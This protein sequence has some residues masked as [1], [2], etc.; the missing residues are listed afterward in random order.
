MG[1]GGSDHPRERGELIHPATG[2]DLD[3]GSSPRARG[4]QVL[5]TGVCQVGRIIPAS[6][7]NSRSRQRPISRATDHPRERGELRAATLGTV[8]VFGSSPR[9]R[10]TRPLFRHA[11]LLRRIIPASAGNSPCCPGSRAAKPDHPRERG[12][13]F[14][15]WRR[16][17]RGC[18]SSPR[19]RG[20]RQAAS[21]PC[22]APR[23]IPASAG[24]SQPVSDTLAAD[25]DHPRERGE[26]ET[27][28]DM[29]ICRA[30]SS[31]RAR[32]TLGKKIGPAKFL[33]IIP[34]SAG[35]SRVRQAPLLHEPDHPRERGELRSAATTFCTKAGSSP[36]ARGTRSRRVQIGRG[37]RIIPASAGNSCGCGCSGTKRPDHPRER[38]ELVTRSSLSR[39]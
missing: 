37:A 22:R 23:I 38:G 13:L 17:A 35:N 5:A 15:C 20:T 39:R 36:R 10:G 14:S 6:A 11:S 3:G 30:G 29:P 33:R 2:R 28:V 19:A 25:P 16:T 26:L 1:A 12:E 27:S 8:L 34:A 9:A 18:G 24:N 32:G 31:P 4:T 7:G 21:P